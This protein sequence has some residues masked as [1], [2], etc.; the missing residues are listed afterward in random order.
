MQTIEP[1]AAQAQST[2]R[3]RMHVLENAHK[4]LSAE[5]SSR[6]EENRT[7]ETILSHTDYESGSGSDE[8]TDGQAPQLVDSP[9]QEL[10][11]EIIPPQQPVS[12][13][14]ESSGTRRPSVPSHSLPHDRSWYQFDLTVVAA[15]V[16]PI[17]NWLTGGD[18][19]KNVLLVSFLLFYLHQIIEVPWS[20]YHKARPRERPPHIHSTRTTAE[21][22]YRI[23][24]SSELRRLEL[25]FLTVAIFSPLVGAYIVRFVSSAVLGDDTFSWF[26]ISLFVF[27][28]G[29]RPWT[30]VIRRV[31]GRITDLHDIIH[32]PAHHPTSNSDFRTELDELRKQY[33]QLTSSIEQLYQ[34]NATH[35]QEMYD[36]V[37]DALD[38][39]EKTMRR[40][41][42]KY[43]KQ[44]GK[45]KDLEVALDGLKK[46]SRPKPP[47]LVVNHKAAP[48]FMEHIT[49]LFPYLPLWLFFY[50]DSKKSISDGRTSPS[51]T[52]TRYSV[53]SPSSPDGLETIVEES[54]AP[55]ET[56]LLNLPAKLF[57]RFAY[58]VTFPLRLISRMIL[59]HS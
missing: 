9:K 13:E 59:G 46:R 43:E 21:E 10:E 19:V 16:S 12:E 42:K 23:L 45:Y 29:V 14:W 39:V 27:A 22:R 3:R 49:L 7:E 4:T 55:P 2:L 24:A 54:G 34:K 25:F 53:R 35:T 48:S 58:L 36:Y 41:E 38:V 32:Y 28:T 57:L 40:Q 30:H 26:S 5:G 1:I 47:A 8:S 33:H 51:S 6:R 17:G 52:V 18:H 31:A 50:P 15:L 56:V 20:L 11:G 44:E 37:D